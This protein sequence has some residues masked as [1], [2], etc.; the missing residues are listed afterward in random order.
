MAA[1]I[2][3]SLDVPYKNEVVTEDFLLTPGWIQFYRLL[4]EYII[5]L[6]IES[7]AKIANNQS[8]AANVTGLQFDFGEK[9]QAN[10]EYIIQRITTGT[11]ATELI[12]TGIFQLAYKP[13]T[14]AWY[15]NTIGTTGP[16]VSGVTFSVTTGGQVQY[17]STN[18][19]G[20]SFISKITYRVRV[21]GAKYAG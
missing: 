7:T 10:V 19:T 8:V 12:Q 1:G 13:I 21:L 16:D 15:M 4:L 5:P 2:N 20:T 14:K 3:R 18:I 6:G 9:N 11:G 17:T